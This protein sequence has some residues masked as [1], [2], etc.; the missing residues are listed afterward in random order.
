MSSRLMDVMQAK[1][2][3]ISPADAKAYVRRLT[4]QDL[5]DEGSDELP[6]I[7]GNLRSKSDLPMQKQMNLSY[8]VFLSWRLA[9]NL[10][11]L[12]CRWGAGVMDGCVRAHML[13]SVCAHVDVG[14]YVRL[15]LSERQR[16]PEAT[17]DE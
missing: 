17:E 5:S 11:D 1:G 7:Q 6:Q 2:K 12:E 8:N 4:C 9:L 13:V 16:R 10:G 15:Y 14:V 3:S